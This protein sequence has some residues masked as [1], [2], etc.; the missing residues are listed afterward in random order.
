[1]S[2]HVRLMLYDYVAGDLT[3]EEARACEEH[4]AG[5]P[6]C[7]DDLRGIREALRLLAPPADSA[8]EERGEEFWDTFAD[9]VEGHLGTPPRRQIMA[10]LPARIAAFTHDNRRPL[11][12]GTGALALA[13]VAAFLFLR[14]G[15]EPAVPRLAAATATDTAAVKLHDYLRKSKV[16]LIGVEN[17][18]REEGVPFDFA[19]ERRQSRALVSE[20][21]F[22]RAQP[23]DA[24]S[25]RLVGE[26]EKI[27]IQLANT[28]ER[29][30]AGGVAIVRSGIRQ[31]NL[32]FRIRMTESVLDAGAAERRSP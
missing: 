20:A 17:A 8:A 12:A 13:A 27:M 32:L 5:C 14:P 15:A 24:R 7:S 9:A 18:R 19:I 28:D 23:L 1:M 29:H 16:L 25:A 4:L 22:L 11:L 3:T 30:D 2:R 31:N 26:I 6:S 10:D 21:R